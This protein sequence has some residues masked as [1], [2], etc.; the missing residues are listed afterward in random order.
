[1]TDLEAQPLRIVS[2]GQTGVDRAA[3][4]AALAAGVPCGGWC[5]AGRRAEDGPIPRCY[6]LREAPSADYA[7]R[8]RLNVRD[9]DGTLVLSTG[10]PEG[11]TALTA[12]HASALGRPLLV[13]DPE[14]PGGVEEAAAW[15]RA[16]RI[17]TLNVAGPRESEVPGVYALARRFVAALLA[18]VSPP[19]GGRT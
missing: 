7:V 18:A 12:E 9:S 8:T 14:A 10:E 13:L 19:R 1:M 5:P 15:M 16:H 11:G 4:D 3:L 2:G 17:G 6:P